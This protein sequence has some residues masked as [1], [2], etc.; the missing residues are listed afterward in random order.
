VRIENLEVRD[1]GGRGIA[2]ARSHYGEVVDV[3]VNGTYVDGIH[4]LSSDYGTVERSL[5]THAGLVFPRDGR[6]HPWGGAIT[7]VDSDFGHVVETTVAE[8]Y[9]EGSNTNHGS[10]GT[11]IESNRVF[12]ARAVGIYADAAPD[13]TI[14][15]N[16]VVGTANSEF[17]RGSA[18]VGPG[19]ALN[20]E[21]YHYRPGSRTL[22]TGIQST[23]AKIEGNLVAYTASGVALWGALEETSHDNLIVSN[24]TLIDNRWQISGLTKA[25]AGGLLVDNVLLSLS[26]GTADVDSSSLSGITARNNYFS[27]GDPGGELSH[28]GNRY[29]GV[30]LSKMSGWRTIDS[31]DDVTWEDLA[32]IVGSAPV[33]S[34]ND[35]PK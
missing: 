8:T 12:A 4:F 11:L 33:D 10:K 20:N 32:S 9:G 26:D 28:P 17:W 35:E 2:F 13:T 30:V 3:V 18:S 31:I 5:V 27:Q 7:F 6:L 23:D 1:S 25:A 34:A 14:R 15:R 19:I 21:E 22:T 29:D 16:I 24:N